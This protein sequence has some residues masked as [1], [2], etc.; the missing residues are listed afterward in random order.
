M[1]VHDDEPF[2]GQPQQS[3]TDRRPAESQELLELDLPEDSSGPK[4]SVTISPWRERY[5]R[6][7]SEAV[8]S[9]GNNLCFNVPASVIVLLRSWAHRWSG[10]ASASAYCSA[11]FV[12]I[13][14]ISVVEHTASHQ[15]TCSRGSRARTRS[16]R[17]ALCEQR[18]R[19]RDVHRLQVLGDEMEGQR[20]ASVPEVLLRQALPHRRLVRGSRVRPPRM[21]LVRRLHPPLREPLEWAAGQVLRRR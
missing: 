3:L 5:A 4:P 6:S 11:T 15:A 2:S 8:S 12:V 14:S 7:A 9:T 20:Y 18:L 1:R 13:A 21:G 19:H 16:T 17:P 10:S